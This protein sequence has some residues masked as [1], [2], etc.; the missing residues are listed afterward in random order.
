M[1]TKAE[2]GANRR[3]AAMSP[4]GV[5]QPTITSKQMRAKNR[6]FTLDLLP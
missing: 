1:L 3:A 5:P 6:G 2:K 4:D